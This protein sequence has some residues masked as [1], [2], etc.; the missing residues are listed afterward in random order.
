MRSHI[1]PL[2]DSVTAAAPHDCFARDAKE[3]AEGW[4]C[5]VLLME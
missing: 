1:A 3:M 2:N 5:V 4:G